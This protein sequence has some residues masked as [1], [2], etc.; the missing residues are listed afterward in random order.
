MERLQPQKKGIRNLQPRHWRRWRRDHGVRTSF[1]F[2]LHPSTI[3]NSTPD[4]CAYIIVSGNFLHRHSPKICPMTTFRGASNNV[5]SKKTQILISISL[6]HRN[7]KSTCHPNGLE[8]VY[9]WLCNFCH[10]PNHFAQVEAFLSKTRM[11]CRWHFTL[12]S[13]F[14][15]E[16]KFWPN[17]GGKACRK[18]SPRARRL[19][20]MPN[21][22][23]H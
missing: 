15:R 5:T 19:P 14:L 10:T 12:E 9:A 3:P 16:T 22:T 2:S 6:F 11:W 17:F 7:P 4:L 23:K 1:P 21:A 8:H 18:E 20:M 13:C